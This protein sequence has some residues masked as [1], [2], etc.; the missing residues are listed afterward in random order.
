MASCEP[1]AQTAAFVVCGLSLIFLRKTA[2]LKP[3]GPRYPLGPIQHDFTT[4]ETNP[5]P[6]GHFAS[7]GGAFGVGGSVS[8][9]S[10]RFKQLNA[11]CGNHF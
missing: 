1:V 10:Q 3:A 9:D 5:T 7:A 4:G 8:F 6:L 2:D 11:Q